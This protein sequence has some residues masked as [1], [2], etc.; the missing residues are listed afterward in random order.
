MVVGDRDGSGLIKS[1]G[2][3]RARVDGGGSSHF[4]PAAPAPAHGKGARSVPMQAKSRFRLRKR[5]EWIA[6]RQPSGGLASGM[7]MDGVNGA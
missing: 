1:S 7:G 6:A 5:R 4:V 3:V 2:L